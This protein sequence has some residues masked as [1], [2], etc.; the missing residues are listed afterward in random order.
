MEGLAELE[1][2]GWEREGEAIS[3][4][5]KFRNFSEA[6]GRMARVALAAEK[7]GHHPDW[8]NSWNT[9]DVSLSTHSE[10]K[11][12]EKDVKLAGVMEKLAG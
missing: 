2:K 11:L 8:S 6:F 3:K 10:G 4:T 5:F 12:T 1:A 7:A 9:V